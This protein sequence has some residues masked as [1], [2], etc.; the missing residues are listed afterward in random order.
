MNLIFISADKAPFTSEKA[1]L[2]LNVHAHAPENSGKIGVENALNQLPAIIHKIYAS[3]LA[4]AVQAASL[5][6]E[7]FTSTEIVVDN[8]ICDINYAKLS[9]PLGNEQLI[10]M[11]SAQTSDGYFDRFGQYGENRFDIETRL[12]HFLSDVQKHN[13]LNT[14]IVVITS[15]FI[16]LLIKRMLNLEFSQNN[17]SGHEQYENVNFLPLNKCTKKL[18]DIKKREIAYRTSLVKECC[19]GQKLKNNLIKIAKQEFNHIEFCTKDFEKYMDGLKTKNLVQ[20]SKATF[21]DD[22][23][24]V[25]FYNNFENFA[26]KWIE[27][28]LSIGVKN[29]VMI[30]NNSTDQSTTILQGYTTKANIAFWSITE[31]YECNKMCGW[32]QQILE[33]YGANK[34]YITVDSDELLTYKGYKHTHVNSFITKHKHQ[35]IKGMMIDV[36]TKKSIGDCTLHDF[37]YADKNTYKKTINDSYGER[38]YGGPRER[39]FGIRPSLQKMPL[40]HYTGKEVF[41]NDHFYYPWSINKKAKLSV[42]LLHYKFLPGDLQKYRAFAED[43]RH[44]N[45]SREYKVYNDVL[46]SNDEASFYNENFSTHIDDLPF[47]N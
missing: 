27:H 38:Y 21:S 16:A 28:Y 37:V 40:M 1:G 24:V 22:A 7:R 31:I 12:T 42:F 6:K 3:P 30:D 10:S 41:A 32:R 19:V 29:F 25:C 20:K 34:V 11:T 4:S 13:F 35:S 46:K 17:Q 23:I 8:R 45:N 44:W 33:F 15:S 47:L 5:V 14:T 36:Y 26:H 43:G 2:P 39:L 18:K 9:V